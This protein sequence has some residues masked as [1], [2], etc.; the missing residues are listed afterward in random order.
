[1]RQKVT[2]NMAASVFRGDRRR[3]SQ[4]GSSRHSREITDANRSGDRLASVGGAGEG[5]RERG[6]EGEETWERNEGK[7][8]GKEAKE[9]V[10]HRKETKEMG[11]NRGSK[12][13]GIGKSEEM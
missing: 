1:M 6:S 7:E 13:E 9:G 3:P 5:G 11:R 4:K 10:E 12:G 2:D 8:K